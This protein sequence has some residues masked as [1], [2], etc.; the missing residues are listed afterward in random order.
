MDG[1]PELERRLIELCGEIHR[2][3][4][5]L[6]PAEHL[7]GLVLGGGY[8]RGHGGVLK[9]QTGDAPYN[10]LEFYVFVRGNPLVNELRYRS[11][12]NELGELLSPTAGLHVEF[13]IDSLEKLRRR[14]V[15][16]FSYDLLC[17]HRILHGDKAIF[18]GCE[19]HRDPRQIVPSEATRLLLN[20]GSGL[21]LV[22]ELLLGKTLTEEQSDFVGRNLAKVELALGDS[23]LA[24]QG[25]YHWDC[26][27]RTR[28][29]LECSLRANWP[30][31]AEITQHH[32][33]GV[34]FKLHPRRI[35]KSITEFSREHEELTTLTLQTWLWLENRRLKSKFSTLEE[36]SL[37]PVKK[38]A[39]TRPWQNLLLN[40]RTFG[41]KAT[42]DKHSPRY[43]RERLFNAL[44]LL[45]A[46][47]APSNRVGAKRHLQQQLLTRADDWHGL[48]AAYKQVWSC[49][50]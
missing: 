5:S 8:G 33:D 9:T 4:L 49:Y 2:R 44:P 40:V 13:K 16:I 41:A 10:D 6:V 30:Q 35:Q 31:A 43:P 1:S 47:G 21:L 50:G 24:A 20:R 12:F 18:S 38:C 7:E 26:R 15:S 29:L 42:F 34:D 11:R 37:S 39:D 19:D 45:L 17:G 36:Y 46:H 25:L 3:T 28:R 48:V 32:S 27:E 14:P 23:L 22:K